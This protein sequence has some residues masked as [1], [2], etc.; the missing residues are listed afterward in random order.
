MAYP[1]AP[2]ARTSYAE[3]LEREDRSDTRHEFLRGEIYAIEGSTPEHSGLVA[4]LAGE[5]GVALHGR[6]CRVFGPNLR[7]HVPGAGLTTYPDV[8]VVCGHLETHPDDPNAV[9]N[10]LVLVE[11]LSD[12]SEAYDRGPKAAHYR[13][14]TSLREYLLV[15]QREPRLELLRRNER[16]VW[17]L[18]EAGVG[19]SIE[20]TSIGVSLSVD[21]VYR[22][23]LVPGSP[24]SSASALARSRGSSR[25][26]ACAVSERGP[27]AGEAARRGAD[28]P[29]RC[30]ESKTRGYRPYLRCFRSEPP[31][32]DPCP[33]LLP[34]Q[35]PK[36]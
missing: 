32:G 25:E 7:V 26:F 15:S 9:T 8:S 2:I 33:T 10:P 4:A 1:A 5:L 22:D 17:E 36:G 31:G 11:V 28:L 23:P 18:H 12:S 14:L 21:R 29:C 3:Y 20:L 6:P 35:A 30:L 34:K 13:K 16:G 19:E 27:F 24:G